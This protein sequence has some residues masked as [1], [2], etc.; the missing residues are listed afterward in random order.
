MV[1][2]SGMGRI[3]NIDDEFGAGGGNL[4]HCDDL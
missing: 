4:T 1:P 3:L 2:E